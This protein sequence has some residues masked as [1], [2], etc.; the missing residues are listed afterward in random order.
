MSQ[1]FKR[2]HATGKIF[3]SR[4]NSKPQDLKTSI[5]IGGSQVSQH[6]DD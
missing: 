3:L 5:I 2:L 4:V 1:T 6:Q